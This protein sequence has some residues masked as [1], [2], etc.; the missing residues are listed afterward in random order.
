MNK[1]M[2][3]LALCVL[4]LLTLAA[5]GCKHE[6]WNEADCVNPKTCAECGETEGEALGHTWVDADCV[7]PKTCSD[8]GETEGEALGHTWVE[9]DYENP[10]TCSVCAVSEGDPLPAPFLGSWVQTTEVSAAE[11]G[12]DDMIV[13]MDDI[14]DRSFSM[15]MI[16]VFHEDDTM[17]INVVPTDM[18][19]FKN[20][21]IDFTE[22]FTYLSMRDTYNM[23]REEV[24][25]LI[26]DNYNMTLREF[27]IALAEQENIDD[28]FSDMN[29]KGTYTLTN[30]GLFMDIA[31]QNVNT[32]PDIANAF[33]VEGDTLT[34][35]WLSIGKEEPTVLTRMAE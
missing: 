6:T 8:C 25:T 30:E 34:L 29:S 12:L 24:D 17:E 31:Y 2:L 21:L 5:C 16:F 14:I 7:A 11:M 33:T 10:K 15:N 23:T 32:D 27:A 35:T 22:E 9:A 1:K 26:M 19:E 13:G 18:E 20:F 4:C 3:C 28:Y